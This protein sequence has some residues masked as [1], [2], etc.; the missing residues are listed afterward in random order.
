MDFPVF[1]LDFIGNRLL[2]AIV[3]VLHVVINHA[4][5]VGAMPLVTLLELKGYRTKDT[6]WDHLAYSILKV[7]FIVTTTVGALTGVG[8]WLSV[9]LV[10]PYG[11]GSLIRVFF[12]AWFTEWLVFIT[13]VCLILAYFLLWKSRT[14]QSKPG[15]ILLGS[16]LSLFSWITMALIVAILGFM[17]DPGAWTV[18]SGLLTAIF[19]PIYLPQL[20][21]RTTLAMVEAGLFAWCLIPGM[22]SDDE[23]R[24]SAVR[25]VARWTLIWSPFL[26]IAALW[27]RSI[28][29][30]AMAANLPVALL[31]QS[32]VVWYPTLQ[33]TVVA[34]VACIAATALVGTARPRLIPSWVLL[35]PFVVSLAMLAEFE[36]VREFI[37]KPYV[38]AGHVYA[39]G[40]REVDVPLLQRDGILKHATYCTTRDIF[41]GNRIE[42]GRD[43]FRLACSRCHTTAGMNNVVAKLEG[44]Y[45][46]GTWDAD[47]VAAY[48]ENMHGVRTYMPPFPGNRDELD[49]MVAYVDSLRNGGDALRLSGDQIVGV[50]RPVEVD[51]AGRVAIWSGVLNDA[52]STVRDRQLALRSVAAISGATAEAVVSGWVG[53][54]EIDDVPPEI[55][56]DVVN[57]GLAA[58]PALKDRITAFL[59]QLDKDESQ[60]RFR[61]SIQGG[62]TTRGAELFQSKTC[63]SCHKMNG[64][65]AETGPD[66][67]HVGGRATREHIVESITSPSAKIAKGYE[68]AM[69]I[70]TDGTVVQG[71]LK[72]ADDKQ[73]VLKLVSGQE[74]AIPADE[75][76]ERVAG[77]SLMPQDLWKTLSRS[78]LRDLVEYLSTRK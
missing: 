35:L 61:L 26:L 36:R 4:M 24:S 41:P 30:E 21:F 9:G 70:R 18:G 69:V 19:N 76:D 42:A 60:A 49:A 74:L 15:H 48:V 58:S 72:R 6:R 23:F 53:R 71:L 67:S 11:L 46:K 1:H 50:V 39:N 65:G 75:V 40:L 27:Y 68:T 73:V 12:W 32:G 31:T 16:A 17:M 63:V 5:A 13:E 34:C 10:N 2:I 57:A 51:A 52:T 55:R 45:G 47:Q 64:A 3:G 59:A 28:V 7:C 14:G 38:I 37:R 66:L 29:P 33:V 43:V 56:L 62:N 54:L 25:W 77:P 8:I 22:V 20:A 44:L 78:E